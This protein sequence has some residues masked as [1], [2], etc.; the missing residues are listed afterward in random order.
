MISAVSPRSS[1]IWVITVKPKR[2]DRQA[3]EIAQSYY[4]HNHPQTAGRLTALAESLTYQKKYDEAVSAL[5]QALA[6]QQSFMVR[7]IRPWLKPSTNWET[8]PPCAIT[9][10]KQ[11]HDSAAQLIS[12]VPSTAITTIWL[13]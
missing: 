5:E 6:I 2:L 3:L 9:S 1:A 13:R 7:Y 12:I 10:M 4:G 11:R 8:W